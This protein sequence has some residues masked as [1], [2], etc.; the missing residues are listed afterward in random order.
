MGKQNKSQWRGRDVVIFIRCQLGEHIKSQGELGTTSET[1]DRTGG[2]AL[3]G[4]AGGFF[5]K[6]Q[7]QDRGK[8]RDCF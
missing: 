1:E 4:G 6:W 8:G 5:R 2:L 3:K 7:Q